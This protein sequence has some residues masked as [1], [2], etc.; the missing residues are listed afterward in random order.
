MGRIVEFGSKIE[1][2]SST[3]TSL[4]KD[5]YFARVAKYVPSEILA[6]YVSMMGIIVS[7]SEN[8]PLRAYIAW[9]AF[10]LC[11]ILTPIY[12]YQFT[13]PKRIKIFHIILSCIAF[14][15]WSYALG[16]PFEISGIYR[17]DIGSLLLIIFTL[18]SGSLKI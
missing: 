11:L 1:L 4:S 6:G 16:G 10:A 12:L 13:A 17:A 18:L 14:A 2:T 7:M 9:T 5:D 15:L 8:D 3:K